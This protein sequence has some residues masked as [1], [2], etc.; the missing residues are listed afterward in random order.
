MTTTSNAMQAGTAVKINHLGAEYTGRTGE[1]CL[2]EPRT[3]I[4]PYSGSAYQ[5]WMVR[6]TDGGRF[7]GRSFEFNSECI[8]VIG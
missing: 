8:E 7:D 1:I 4:S 6:F 2:S 3:R 5:V